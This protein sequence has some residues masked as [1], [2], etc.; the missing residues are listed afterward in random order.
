MGTRVL[1]LAFVFPVVLMLSAGCAGSDKTTLNGQRVYEKE[2][3]DRPPTLIAFGSFRFS[4]TSEPG[5][6]ALRDAVVGFVVNLEGEP[7]RVRMV[8]GTGNRNADRSLV[9]KVSADRYVPGLLDG[10]PVPV[11]MTLDFNFGR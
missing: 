5:R 3:V 1:L 8:R 11:R 9:Q 2:E 7:V 10:E 6:T 4:Y